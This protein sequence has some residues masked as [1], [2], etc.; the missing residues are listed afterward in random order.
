MPITSTLT[1]IRVHNKNLL[2][3]NEI[4]CYPIRNITRPIDLFASFPKPSQTFVPINPPSPPLRV[5][6]KENSTLKIHTSTQNKTDCN[7]SAYGGTI[8]LRKSRAAAASSASPIRCRSAGSLTT[9]FTSLKD[10]KNF[11]NNSRVAKQFV[12]RVSSLSPVGRKIEKRKQNS[13]PI[14]FGRS[15]SKER[16]FAEEKKKQEQRLPM[17]KRAWTAS[18]SI[19]RDP[20]VKSSNEVRQAVRNTYKS[21]QMRER[22]ISTSSTGKT[23]TGNTVKTSTVTYA[24]DK[25]LKDSIKNDEQTMRMSVETLGKSTPIVMKSK[26]TKSTVNT[27]TKMN[28]RSKETTKTSS[29]ISLARTNST[30]SIDSSSSKRRIRNRPTVVKSTPKPIDYPLTI[31]SKTRKKIP[32]EKSIHDTKPKPKLKH[33]QSVPYS[34]TITSKLKTVGPTQK[35]SERS[36]SFIMIKNVSENNSTVRNRKQE[37]TSRSDKFFQNLFLKENKRTGVPKVQMVRE[38]TAVQEKAYFWNTIPRRVHSAAKKPP[39]SI[40]LAQ[41]QAVTG[42]KFKAK[43]SD[44]LMP[45]NKSPKVLHFDR[46]SKFDSFFE[47][48]DEDG[49]EFGCSRYNYLYEER[50][51]SEPRSVTYIDHT[52]E[53]I[54]SKATLSKDA[55]ERPFSPTREIRSPSS[56]RIQ[57]LR[58]QNKPNVIVGID[59]HRR[60]HSLDSRLKKRHSCSIDA[61]NYENHLELCSHGRSE[62]FK[63]LNRFYSHVERVGQL[64]R[65][66]SNTDLHPIRKENQ[67]IDYDVWK[68]VRNYERA[69]RELNNLV[70]KLKKD[71]KEKDFLFRPKYAEDTK[72]CKHFESGLRVKEKSVE[73]L[74][75]IFIEKSLKNELDEI[76]RKNIESANDNYKSLWRGNS[77]LDLASSMVV[78]YNPQIKRNK[79]FHDDRLG[80]SRNLISTLSK[81]QVNKIKNQLTEIY[82]NSGKGTHKVDSLPS[83]EFVVNVYEEHTVRPTSLI[84]RSNS[85]VGEKELLKPVLKRQEER[86]KSFKAD[87]IGNVHETRVTRSVDRYDSIVRR[88]VQTYSEDEKKKLMQQLGNEIRDKLKERQ[89][90]VLQPR[91]TR[92]AIATEKSKEKKQKGP[93]QQI[94]DRK[95]N[96]IQSLQDGRKQENKISSK[97]SK[98]ID[99]ESSITVG[100]EEKYE[101]GLSHRSIETNVTKTLGKSKSNADPLKEHVK[102]KIDYFEKKKDEKVPK[103][104]YLPFDDSSPDEDEIIRLV[105]ENVKLRSLNKSA[106]TQSK[107]S[108]RGLST[109]ASDLKEIFGEKESVRNLIEFSSPTP[110]ENE[111][112]SKNESESA[113]VENF[114][115]SRSISPICDSKHS[116]LKKKKREKIA[117]DTKNSTPI[118]VVPS[119]RSRSD[120]SLNDVIYKSQSPSKTIIKDHEAGNVSYI[121]HKFELKK[122]AASRSRARTCR[123]VSPIQRVAFKN[124]YRLMPH[125]D[126]ISK[127]IAL[128]ESINCGTSPRSVS[129][130]A[131]NRTGEVE[132]I[133]HIFEQQTLPDH[134]SLIGQMYTSTPD[135]SELKDIS[136]YLSGTWI[137]HKYPKPNDNARS[138]TE[139]EKG[140]TRQEI[141]RKQTSSRS[142]STSPLHSMQ[143]NTITAE[144]L[145]PYHNVFDDQNFDPNKHRPTHRYIPIDKRIE[146]EYLWQ[147]LKKQNIGGNDNNKLMKKSQGWNK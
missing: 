41:K 21:P 16:T 76:K 46:V 105:S 43:E 18:T 9:S 61:V 31:S 71:E 28:P 94:S 25:L 145:K 139:P 12:Q 100:V 55:K 79:S 19:L 39:Q 1:K 66:T 37:H 97:K 13:S 65:T 68:Q 49:N 92:G 82:S 133:R 93:I 99:T 40:Y 15:I 89:E 24:K 85:L 147:R 102:G 75:E 20:F 110:G 143:Q 38:N 58:V 83:E 144:M 60:Y 141:K 119:R 52:K 2:P 57:S 74:K 53:T 34:S 95:L 103:T 90:K 130:G 112:Q 10:E 11:A 44:K 121:T 70:G 33:I 108:S 67:L 131:E 122:M 35:V 117:N 142:N 4:L 98:P 134:I 104:I 114:F 87:S 26:L 127:T 138:A 48:S 3:R 59:E 8:T 64:E 45:P 62:K 140:P 125:I 32:D 135:I 80:I 136:S 106:T 69:E 91:E 27:E 118:Y 51:K 30:F 17:C 146:A 72:W 78:K 123:I 101:N 96:I 132:K 115:R 56:R 124:D 23:A 47:L 36:N 54:A 109:S 29:S 113:S 137:A 50:S 116:S 120:P 128:K 77:V 7:P 126:I 111:H 129:I 14:A 81:D 42:S 73:D 63:D 84:V 107:L 6:S 22:F 5:S 88:Q 86:M